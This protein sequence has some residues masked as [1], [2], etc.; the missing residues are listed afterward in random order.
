[1]DTE[2]LETRSSR[3]RPLKLTEAKVS[4]GTTHNE[5]DFGR[6]VRLIFVV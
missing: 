6:L 4:G 5:D 3:F 1:M 2:V